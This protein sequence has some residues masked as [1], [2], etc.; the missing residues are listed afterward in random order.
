LSPVGLALKSYTIAR[1]HREC[2]FIYSRK[3]RTSIPV[4]IKETPKSLT[5][6]YVDF[7]HP[8]PTKSDIKYGIHREMIVHAHK[9]S[10]VFITPSFTEPIFNGTFVS[11]AYKQLLVQIG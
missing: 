5:E 1:K 7:L 6:I 8:E 3:V 11:I 2:N 9:Y 4:S 10:T